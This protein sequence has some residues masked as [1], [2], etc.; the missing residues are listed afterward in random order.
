M[1]PV[2]QASI[3]E[4]LAKLAGVFMARLR[5]AFPQVFLAYIK[6]PAGHLLAMPRQ[7]VVQSCYSLFRW[8]MRTEIRANR[9]ARGFPNFA[10]RCSRLHSGR[11]M[12]F[13][14]HTREHR[15]LRVRIIT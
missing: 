3:R 7:H 1:F 11:F 9:F 6:H 8:R 10:S 12:E 4:N 15:W 2:S 13:C 14:F 5:D